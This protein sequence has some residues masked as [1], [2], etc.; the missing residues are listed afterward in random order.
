MRLIGI[1]QGF[2]G[3]NVHVSCFIRIDLISLPLKLNRE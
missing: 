2:R 3:I 1:V